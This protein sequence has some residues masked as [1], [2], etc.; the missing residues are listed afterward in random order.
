M[1]ARRQGQI[2]KKAEFDSRLPY[3]W[4]LMSSLVIISSV[5]G[6]P[7]LLFWWL[8]LGLYIHRRQFRVLEAELTGATLQA[9]G[10]RIEISCDPLA[11]QKVWVASMTE[12]DSD[13]DGQV[14]FPVASDFWPHGEVTRAFD[15]FNEDRGTAKRSVFIIDGE[16]IIRWSNVYTDS[17]PASGELLHEIENL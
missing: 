3:Y 14:P 2:L 12:D 5:V 4:L 15:V 7:L 8:G 13:E 11:V 1:S 17:I 6:I 10:G 16:G 9:L